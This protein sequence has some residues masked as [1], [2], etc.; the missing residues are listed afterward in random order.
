MK[1][2]R[3]LTDAE[4]LAVQ[5]ALARGRQFARNRAL[6]V[7]GLRTGFRIS[8]LLALNVGDVFR[9][10]DVTRSVYAGRCTTKGKREGQML[11]LHEHARRAIRSL[12]DELLIDDAAAADA[13][14][15]QSR[16]G[17]RRLNRRSAWEMLK[18]AFNACG[19]DGKLACHTMRKTFAKRMRAQVGG[20]LY[21]LKKLLAH[22]DIRA[23]EKYLD[24]DAEE[25]EAAV[26][27]G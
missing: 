7:V 21:K 20:D 5:S 2:C 12:V 17:R 9:N 4:D 1:G 26:L 14:L 23:T 11:P 6:F 24:F 22:T 3:P 15:F 8:Q 16:K 19:L 25:L 27:R 18:A 13:P 10:G